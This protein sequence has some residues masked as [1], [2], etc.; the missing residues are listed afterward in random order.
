MCQVSNDV[1]WQ[2]ALEQSNAKHTTLRVV[3]FH[4]VPNESKSNNAQKNRS[5]P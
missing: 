1:T 5:K 4:E 3:D 2:Q